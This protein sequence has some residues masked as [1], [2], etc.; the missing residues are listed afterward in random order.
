MSFIVDKKAYRTSL[1][2]M[3]AGH[4]VIAQLYLKK[5]YGK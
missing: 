3:A 2:F 4:E 1:L 5:A